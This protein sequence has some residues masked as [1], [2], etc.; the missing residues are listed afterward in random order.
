MNKKIREIVYAKYKGHCAY[1]GCELEMKDMQIDHIV[2]K[3]RNYERWAKEIG[4]DDIDNLNPSCRMCNYYKRMDSLEVFREGLTD[5]LMRNVRR[6]FD[7]R[8]AVKYGL[9]KEDVKK[10]KF[11]FESQ[12][13]KVKEMKTIEERADAYV[14][15]PFE[16]DEFSST[17]AKRQA[18]IDGAKE[19]RKIDIDKACQWFGEYLMNIGYP[20][21]WYRDS[22]VQMSGEERFRKAME[23]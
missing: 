19:Q 6:P 10:V 21:D 5:M 7:Y 22:L 4:T 14:G 12:G 17:T 20:D 11:Y 9:V 16:I 18:F 23:E 15:H 2:P 1:C 8:L 3:C 13:V